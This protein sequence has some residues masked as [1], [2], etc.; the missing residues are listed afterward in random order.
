MP[1]DVIP[2]VLPFK[3]EDDQIRWILGRPNFAVAYI[4]R[5]LREAGV[6]CKTNAEDEQAA[7]IYWML[8]MYVK[9]GEEWMDIGNKHL[10]YL[11][12]LASEA[13]DATPDT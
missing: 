8:S 13:E 5:I 2:D 1:E 10:A 7:A 6:P 4:A 9:H 11:K 12:H 3:L